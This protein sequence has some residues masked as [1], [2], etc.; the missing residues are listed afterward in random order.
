VLKKIAESPLAEI[1]F[2]A[3]EIVIRKLV[4]NH[5]NHKFRLL[6]AKSAVE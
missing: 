3:L 6:R 1:W 2:E 5:D 4:E